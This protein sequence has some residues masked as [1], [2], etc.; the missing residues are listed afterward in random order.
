MCSMVTE[1]PTERLVTRGVCLT[2]IQLGI[3]SIAVNTS[4]HGHWTELPDYY[5]FGITIWT[6]LR[7]KT[8]ITPRIHYKNVK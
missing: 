1:I 7:S 8:I 5:F 3:G 6:T 2:E 4:V